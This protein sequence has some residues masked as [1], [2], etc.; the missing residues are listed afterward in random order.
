MEITSK[1]YPRDPSEWRLWLE[2]HHLNEKE[3]WLIFRKNDM[4]VR[5][6]NYL[7]AVE[8]ALCFG[9][10][11]GISKKISEVDTA[12]RFTP[13]SKK[14][15]WTELN[16]ER[17]RRLIRLGKMTEAGFKVLPDLSED[18]FVIK[19]EVLRAIEADTQTF[20]NF[21]ALPPL[22]IRVRISNIQEYPVHSP[23][24]DKRLSTFLS[25]T[26]ANKCYGNWNDDGKL[27]EI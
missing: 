5:P 16:K 17:A 11:D 2:A 12:Q 9:W 8:E 21:K 19:P 23:E 26:K 7:E 25:H 22:Y 1:I 4:G 3:I 6:V 15:H 20:E 24:Y 27:I 14:S 13:R 10:I 18:S